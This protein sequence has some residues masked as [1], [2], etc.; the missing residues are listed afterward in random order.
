[1]LRLKQQQIA[2]N[3][4]SKQSAEI[5]AKYAVELEDNKTLK[6]QLEVSQT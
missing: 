5:T 2:Q 4:Q 6:Q 1:M 3:Q